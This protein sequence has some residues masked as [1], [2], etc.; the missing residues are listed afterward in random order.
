M[1]ERF[2]V[3]S[4]SELARLVECPNSHKAQAG[5]AEDESKDSSFGDHVH[6]F[7]S[8]DMPWDELTPQEQAS[9]ELCADAEQWHVDAWKYESEDLFDIRETRLG[10]TA[11][12]TVL[13][14]AKF[15][16]AAYQFTGKMDLLVIQGKRGLLIDFKS[17]RPDVEDP[18]DNAQLM[19]LAVLVAERYN[20]VSI[21]AVIIAPFQARKP[22]VD[23]D[24]RGLQMARI[25]LAQTLENERNSTEADRKPGKWCK[26]CKAALKGCSA[27][28]HG[29]LQEVETVNPM[30]IA[31]MPGEQ[32]RSAMWSIAMNRTPEQHEAAYNGLAMIKRYV[33]VMEQ[34]F[35]ARVEA[36]EVPGWIVQESPGNRE[37]EDAQKAYE[38]LA[39]LGVT[40][41]QVLAACK[42]SITALDDAVRVASGVKSV[43][44]S[45][46]VKYNL[47]AKDAKRE[48]EAAL[49]P[50]MTRGNPKKSIIKVNQIEE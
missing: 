21:R 42:P 45:G 39:H 6:A 38:L 40:Q 11:M 10:L 5:L 24:A 15:P 46:A 35:K 3:P 27:L 9:A 13:E 37:V 49:A 12:N 28:H 47:T 7:L 25:W 31:G 44:A 50:I 34:S 16:K 48:L 2:G 19:G 30:A 20:L 17:L 33:D 18:V 22:P 41:E 36:G 4:A 1:D 8:G 23:Y 43:T 26:Y 14:T 29:V 32:Q